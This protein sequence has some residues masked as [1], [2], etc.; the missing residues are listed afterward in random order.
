MR[1]NIG[2]VPFFFS[3]SFALKKEKR[4]KTIL[5]FLGEIR[6]KIE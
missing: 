5:F 3:K 2:R 4:G 6:E 1:K